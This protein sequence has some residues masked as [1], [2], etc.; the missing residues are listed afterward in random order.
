MRV[1]AFVLATSFAFGQAVCAASPARIASLNLCPDELLLALAAPE[2]IAS[3]T[4]LSHD[5][6]ESTLWRQAARYS[7]NDGTILS[8]ASIRPDLI[9]TMGGGGRDSERLAH[10][11]G[12]QLIHVPFPSSLGDVEASVI[13]ISQAIGRPR[14][15]ANLLARIRQAVATRPKRSRNAIFVDS[16]NRSLSPDSAGAQWLALAGFRQIP[17]EGDSFDRELLLR[18]PPVTLILNNYRLDQYSRIEASPIGRAQDRRLYTDGRPW[19]C[20]GPTMLP[21]IMRLRA[22][23]GR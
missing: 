2:Q 6:R 21:E 15:G 8:V 10:A 1:F 22:M 7:S 19:T 13:T 16:G 18:A 17:V 5:S 12:A 9:V 14:Q 4:H 11:L 23:A 20:L 3:L